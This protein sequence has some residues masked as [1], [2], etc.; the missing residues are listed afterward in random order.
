M[1]RGAPTRPSAR[2][3]TAS[4]PPRAARTST[5]SGPAIVKAV[6]NYIDTQTSTPKGVTLDRRGHPRGARRRALG[7]RARAAVPGPDQGPAQ[8]P[9]GAGAGR[10]RRPP[11]ARA[12]A[13]RQHAPRAT[14]SSRASSWRRGARGVARGRAGGVAQDRGHPPAEPAGQAR[15]LR[16]DRSRRAASC[17]SSRATR[18]GGSAKQ[19]RDRR[20]QA[21]LPLR[22]KVLNAEQASLQKVL[23]NKELQDIVSALG[24]GVGKDF[25]ARAA[26]LRQDLPA[27][28]RRH[29]TATTSRRCC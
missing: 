10:R 3:S 5:A 24:C 28:G 19:G 7:L 29:A 1:D 17:S 27:D 15:R 8:Q 4:R 13:A 14:R 18:A 26:A 25:D 11:G 20:T 6:R 21:I 16:V 12:V 9:R 2:T 23:A 22:G